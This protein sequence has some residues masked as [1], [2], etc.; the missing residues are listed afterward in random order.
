[1]SLASPQWGFE[2]AAG[3]VRV[4]AGFVRVR[5]GAGFVRVRVGAGFVRVG[6]GFVKYW[7]YSLGPWPPDP[8][9][10]QAHPLSAQPIV[11]ELPVQPTQLGALAAID[12]T[13]FE[14]YCLVQPH[15]P[16]I[17]LGAS[18]HGFLARSPWLLLPH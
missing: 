17:W 6:S 16:L 14:F 11:L 12:W 9:H 13:A 15:H 1:M 7:D 5:V 18:C 3:F 2:W 10:G 8:S 4:G